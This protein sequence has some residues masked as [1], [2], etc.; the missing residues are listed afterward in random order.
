MYFR[1]AIQVED[2]PAWTWKSSILGSFELLVSW[3]RYYCILPVT[4]LCIF[5]ATSAGA[6]YTSLAP[7]EGQELWVTSVPAGQG[8]GSCR[9]GRQE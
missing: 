3:L 2:I 5:V 6:L 7:A 9:R 4:R 8:A 1:I